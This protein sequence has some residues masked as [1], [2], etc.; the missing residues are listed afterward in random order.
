MQR[1]IIILI[2]LYSVNFLC[3]A[4]TQ[5]EM[6]FYQSMKPN[7]SGEKITLET[8]RHFYCINERLFFS[9]DYKFNNQNDGILW[10]NV[11]YVE[12]I[13]WNGEKIAQAKFKI[14]DGGASGYLIIPNT[15]L[16]GNYYLRAYTRWMRNYEAE[17]YAYKVIKILNPHVNNID[18]GRTDEPDEKAIY[19]KPASGNTFNGIECFTDKNSYKQR[20][21]IDLTLR[22][23]NTE[24]DDSGFCISIAKTGSIDTNNYHFQ[25]SGKGLSDEDTLTYLPEIR[26]ISISGKIID[27]SS[28]SPIP[29]AVLNLSIPQDFR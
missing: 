15:L 9:A 18:D 4:Q 12:L 26:G 27:A 21:K 7:E 8:D 24:Q 19:L 5:P 2:S 10:S 29:N 16:S 28:R 20:D 1:I 14:K 6:S 13:R 17:K 3:F 23:H 22:L 25:V 11:L